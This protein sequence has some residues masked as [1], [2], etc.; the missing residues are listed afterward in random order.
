M[1]NRRE[2]RRGLGAAAPAQRLEIL[3]SLDLPADTLNSSVSRPRTES[4]SRYRIEV[5]TRD[6]LLRKLDLCLNPIEK[7]IILSYFSNGMTVTS[8]K[9]VGTE[10][11]RGGQDSCFAKKL[12][13]AG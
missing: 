3:E 1:N 4:K 5:E 7:S 9:V 2:S 12:R 11:R 13:A 8:D 10:Q 6:S